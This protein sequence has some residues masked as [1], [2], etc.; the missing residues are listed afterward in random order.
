MITSAQI[1]MLHIAQRQLEI[2]REH[3]EAIML[4]AA[5]VTSSKALDNAGFD[6]VI[7]R[8]EELGFRNT[9]RHSRR[10]YH[11]AEPITHAQQQ[12]IEGLYL[13]LGWDDRDRQIGF[14]RRQCRKSWPQTRRDANRVIEGLKAIRARSSRS[15]G[16]GLLELLVVIAVLGLL[17]CGAAVGKDRTATPPARTVIPYLEAST[18]PYLATEFSAIRDAENYIELLPLQEAVTAVITRWDDPDDTSNTFIVLHRTNPWPA[19]AARIPLRVGVLD[20]DSPA[21]LFN[22]REWYAMQGYKTA[23]ATGVGTRRYLLVIDQGPL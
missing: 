19:H 5:G 7:R 8:F 14:N 9:A 22:T 20:F 16:L 13:E 11:P 21:A 15:A 17:L 10:P 6:A 18:H 23:M 3:Y 2:P 1:R 12:L 4:E